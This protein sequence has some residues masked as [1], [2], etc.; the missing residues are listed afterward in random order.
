[1]YDWWRE[2]RFCFRYY[3]YSGAAVCI[4]FLIHISQGKITIHYTGVAISDGC[5]LR[6]YDFFAHEY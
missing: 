3:S 2:Q 6:Y 4:R 1:M 5:L